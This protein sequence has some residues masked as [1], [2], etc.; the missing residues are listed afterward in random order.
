MQLAG[1][2]VW[3]SREGSHEGC[4]HADAALRILSQEDGASMNAASARGRYLTGQAPHGSCG[5][6]P[7][8]RGE[9]SPCSFC[10]TPMSSMQGTGRPLP[11]TRD[12]HCGGP[13][14]WPRRC[15]PSLPSASGGGHS[16]QHVDK[17]MGSPGERPPSLVLRKGEWSAFSG[18]QAGRVRCAPCILPG[19]VRQA[20]D[21]SGGAWKASMPRGHPGW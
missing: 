4:E 8:V 19:G 5:S 10:R 7:T 16:N 3:L 13:R 2:S 20:L 1:R 17:L 6:G 9:E 21:V 11:E 18:C 12:P 15:L 14:G